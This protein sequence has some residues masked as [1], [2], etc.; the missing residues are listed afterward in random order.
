MT[1]REALEAWAALCAGGRT[2]GY[3]LVRLN[4][5]DGTVSNG[6]VHTWPDELER[7]SRIALRRPTDMLI[8]VV[9]RTVRDPDAV[10]EGSMLWACLSGSASTRLLERFRPW[11]AI[12]LREGDTMR[13]TAAWPLRKALAY[14]WL[15]KANRRIAHYLRAPKM[16]CAPETLLHP[17]GALILGERVSP[18]PIVVE[19][20]EPDMFTAKDVVRGLRDAP[21]P[22]AWRDAA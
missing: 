3:H 16:T 18:V 4:E 6:Y 17:P 12:V 13:R 10:R 2:D 11:P 22:K 1:D 19:R 21:D 15:V 14:D 7:L 8:G 9:P 5:E 20:F